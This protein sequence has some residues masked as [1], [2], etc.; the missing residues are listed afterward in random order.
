MNIDLQFYKKKFSKSLIDINVYHIMK[1]NI[2]YNIIA[3]TIISYL[4]QNCIKVNEI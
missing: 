1:R 3:E 2:K 4:L